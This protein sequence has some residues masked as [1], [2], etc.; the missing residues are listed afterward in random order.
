[1]N[2]SYNIQYYYIPCFSINIKQVGPVIIKL[3]MVRDET[4]PEFRNSRIWVL[5]LILT[6]SV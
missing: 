6:G 1:M 2:S 3:I 5:N 4:K